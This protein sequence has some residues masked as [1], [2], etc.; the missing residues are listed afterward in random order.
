MRFL[1]GFYQNFSR[2]VISLSE[3]VGLVSFAAMFTSFTI[4]L[5]QRRKLVK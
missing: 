5:M 4:I 2:G 1:I 3:V